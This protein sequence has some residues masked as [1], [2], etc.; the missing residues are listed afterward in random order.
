[1]RASLQMQAAQGPWRKAG[2]VCLALVLLGVAVLCLQQPWSP[3]S[4]YLLVVDAGSSG[5]R[6]NAYRWRW[7]GGT[8]RAYDRVETEPALEALLPD[9]ARLEREGLRPL[10]RWARAVVPATQRA[11]TPVLLAGTAGLRRLDDATQAALLRAVRAVLARSGFLF[12]PDWASVIS[13]TDEGLY[14]WVALNYEEQRLRRGSPRRGAGPATLGALDLGGSS[15]EI[16]FESPAPAAPLAGPHGYLS[17]ALLGRPRD[18]FCRVHHGYGLNDAFDRSV[19]ALLE[20]AGP[21]RPGTGRRALESP[22]DGANASAIACAALATHVASGGAAA[23]C[24]LPPCALGVHQPVPP[25]EARFAALSGFYVVHRFF[26][27]PTGVG[28]GARLDELARRGRDFCALN[29]TE[30]AALHSGEPKLEE[31]CFRAPYVSALL[32]EGLGLRPEAVS[33]GG[34]GA[35][36]PLGLALVRGTAA[37]GATPLLLRPG[38]PALALAA[39]AVAAAL[40]ALCRLRAGRAAGAE[41]RTLGR[42]ART[43]SLAAL[44]QA[45][46][47]AGSG[48]KPPSDDSN[49]GPALGRKLDASPQRLRSGNIMRRQG[50]ISA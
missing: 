8:P 21:G 25:A 6:L 38:L 12:R 4:R 27:L 40:V 47:G 18:L 46:S 15:L 7:S 14:G 50:S 31:Y 1:M 11:S 26:G 42:E 29:W 5:T 39:V 23:A 37:F 35:G 24:E 48:P 28:R 22:A 33:V 36:W 34:Q 43:A 10:L 17:L 32:R 2:L 44:L 13:G 16:C 9:A 45:E 3:G 30:A 20:A 19:R 49:G 41:P